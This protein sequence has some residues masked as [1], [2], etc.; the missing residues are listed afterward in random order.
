M[1]QIVLSVFAVGCF[2]VTAADAATTIPT[3]FQ[4]DW[5]PNCKATKNPQDTE[6][7]MSIVRIDTTS[8][9]YGEAQCTLLKTSTND[10]SHIGGTFDCIGDGVGGKEALDLRLKSGKLRL[11]DRARNIWHSTDDLSRCM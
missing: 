2:V 3:P 11:I 10:A 9:S 1:K 6:A 8:V 5:A 4:G 7:A